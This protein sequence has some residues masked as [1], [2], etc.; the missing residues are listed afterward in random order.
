MGSIQRVILFGSAVSMGHH[1]DGLPKIW[2]NLNNTSV[3]GKISIDELQILNKQHIKN[4]GNLHCP[5]GKFFIIVFFLI[6][7]VFFEL[8]KQQL[9]PMDL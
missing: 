9:L 8:Q 4:K 7:A 6:L 5:A 3:A 1:L 2:V